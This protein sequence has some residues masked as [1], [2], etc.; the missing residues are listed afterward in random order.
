MVLSGGGAKGLAHIGVLKAIDKAGLKVDYVTG[1]SI[2]AIVGGLY[3]AGYTGDQ[4][5]QIV[6]DIDWQQLFSGKPSYRA[7]GMDEKD[8]FENYTVVLPMRDFKPVLP[9][10]VVEAQ[11]LW[12][13]FGELFFP[14]YDVRDFSQLSI[15]FQCVA[16]DLKTGKAVHLTGG[17]LVSSIR[18][19]MAI[20]GVFSAVD[21]DG[22][23]LFD[24]GVI[25]NFPVEEVVGMG[26]DIVIGVNLTPEL[27]KASE[28]KSPLDVVTQL[29]VY[30]ISNNIEE[31]KRLCN[32]LVEPALNDYSPASFEKDNAI[33]AIGD[34]IGDKFYPR[35]KALA[36]SLAQ[37]EPVEVNTDSR[38]PQVK[39]VVIDEVVVEGLEKTDKSLL[40]Q[41]LDIVPGKSYTPQEINNAFRHAYSLLYYRHLNYHLL[42]TQ[43]GHAQ[44]KVSLKEAELNRLMLG[45]SYHTFSDAAL[46]AGYSMRDFLG[47][48]SRTL[49]KVALGHNWR[50]KLNHKQ[51]FGER[52]NNVWEIQGTADKLHIP[53]YVDTDLTN[54]Y[55]TLIYGAHVGY[56][57]LLSSSL[58][59]GARVGTGTAYFNPD[60][61]RSKTMSGYSGSNFAS[62]FVH[63]NSLNNRYLP[64]KGRFLSVDATMDVNRYYRYTDVSL[65]GSQLDRFSS[66]KWRFS[67][68]YESYVPISSYFVLF[69]K[70]KAGYVENGQEHMYDRFLLGG[71]QKL[72][73]VHVPFVGIKEGQ[74]SS[75]SYLTSTLGVK[76]RFWGDFHASAMANVGIIDF[77]R[78]FSSRFLEPSTFISGYGIGINYNL[79]VLP[80]EYNL[81]YSPVTKTVLSHICIGFLF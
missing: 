73:S 67:V 76:Y 17:D 16:T 53:E 27:E 21:Y 72:Y 69:D 12:Y 45:L 58:A 39:S 63:H 23:R 38:L 68:D 3:A 11:E 13:K 48:Q 4:I 81:M 43:T 37:I 6:Y 74:L 40:M 36:D 70:F 62:F 64:T 24:G 54:N 71:V 9:T 60:I 75:K 79:N 2:G 15:P 52:L 56:S 26:A 29:F 8:E 22:K 25:R 28:L 80:I 19:S 55:N 1:T 10:G 33:M 32:V 65:G 30:V 57:R 66:P 51:A 14:V 47:D 34:D 59:V 78:P 77:D 20:P 42:P 5:E 50:V 35:F 7:V 18:A 46:I 44:L 61:A 49:L 41:S 31:D